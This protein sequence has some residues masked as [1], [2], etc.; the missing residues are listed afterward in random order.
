[1]SVSYSLPVWAWVY[2][3]VDEL[4]LRFLILRNLYDLSLTVSKDGENVAYTAHV[5]F[6]GRQILA[7][8]VAVLSA[9]NAV[10][11]PTLRL[12]QRLYRCV[13]PKPLLELQ[14]VVLPD[15]RVRRGLIQ[16]EPQELHG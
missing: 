2:E 4:Y 7:R 11:S 10:L 6:A 3:A 14:V 1:M 13:R 8:A 16:D 5:R 9:G 12:H 15:F